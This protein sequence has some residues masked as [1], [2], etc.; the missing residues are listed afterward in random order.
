[1]KGLY[2]SLSAM[3]AMAGSVSAAD[4]AVS[5]KVFYIENGTQNAVANAKVSVG[6]AY[7]TTDTNGNY[8]INVAEGNANFHIKCPYDTSLAAPRDYTLA[9]NGNITDANFQ[10][11]KGV[12]KE[13]TVTYLFE[14]FDDWATG[15][16]HEM[17]NYNELPENWG[18]ITGS[19]SA[20]GDITVTKLN[21]YSG[22]SLSGPG[23]SYEPSI[24]FPV[25]GDDDYGVDVSFYA[26]SYYKQANQHIDFFIATKNDDGTF[27][28]NDNYKDR[29]ENEDLSTT[30]QQYTVHFESTIIDSSDNQYM[31]LK[32]NGR[33]YLDNLEVSYKVCWVEPITE[34]ITGT[35]TT[36]VSTPVEGA[37]VTITGQ[38]A[39]TTDYKYTT[40]TNANGKY[41]I[42]NV[43]SN[44]NYAVSVSG[45]T[46][47]YTDASSNLFVDSDEETTCDTNLSYSVNPDVTC[48][49]TLHQLSSSDTTSGNGSVARLDF[50]H[51]NEVVATQN[52]TLNA[53][54]T[55]TFT[56]DGVGGFAAQ[57]CTIRASLD[58]YYQTEVASY[59]TFDGITSANLNS[60]KN[61]DIHMRKQNVVKAF[62]SKES[63]SGTVAYFYIKFPEHKLSLNNTN[64]RVILTTVNPSS[65]P[66]SVRGLRTTTWSSSVIPM[67][68][69]VVTDS[70]GEDY[71][72]VTKDMDL[73]WNIPTQTTTY[74]LVIPES[75]INIDNYTYDHELVYEQGIATGVDSVVVS[76][77][78]L[79][80]IYDPSGAVVKRGVNADA[81]DT[82][83]KGIYIVK[84]TSGAYKYVK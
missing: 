70:N 24:V 46:I 76:D 66:A 63:L 82:L 32:L 83:P 7:A 56:V 8:S 30:Y 3:L 36:G 15:S 20:S 48:T 18:Y 10:V 42:A 45:P 5:G 53:D 28:R 12:Q 55:A 25:K 11:V 6:D 62:E 38:V 47:G 79:L 14:D 71:I 54:N 41:S 26:R 13:Q 43:L 72:K 65:T 17:Y 31:A 58:G 33:N 37:T 40:T 1:M 78:E 21:A 19:D 52:V 77:T 35:V 60:T 44:L 69:E 51:D 84:G 57:D 39:G 2:L 9:V 27:S 22:L 50:I 74:Y 67:K 64:S 23:G 4:Y 75:M 59:T 80:D 81:L 61:I 68:A 16:V 29:V 73:A 49:V 34:T